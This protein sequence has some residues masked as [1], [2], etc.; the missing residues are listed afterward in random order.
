MPAKEYL[1]RAGV[2]GHAAETIRKDQVKTKKPARKPS[3]PKRKC[4]VGEI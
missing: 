2:T 4:G 3:I 1:R